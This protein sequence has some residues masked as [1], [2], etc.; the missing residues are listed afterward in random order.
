MSKR[1]RRASASAA[2][3]VADPKEA[4]EALYRAAAQRYCDLVDAA[5]EATGQDG[6]QFID[7]RT[8]IRSFKEQ[9]SRAQCVEPTGRVRQKVQE[10][11]VLERRRR[12]AAGIDAA[13]NPASPRRDKKARATPTPSTITKG[14]AAAAAEDNG[15]H[16][17]HRSH[18]P[19]T[20]A[21]RLCSRS[22]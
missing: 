9:T 17:P 13:A 18:R 10:L 6:D 5:K 21:S 2:A 19:C 1:P 11:I 20:T 22:V 8:T 12:D 7:F 14:V 4:M 3:A 16:R 15:A